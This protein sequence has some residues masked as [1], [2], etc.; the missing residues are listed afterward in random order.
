MCKARFTTLKTF[1]LNSEIKDDTKSKNNDETPVELIREDFLERLAEII[2]R[3]S[4]EE[5]AS[6]EHLDLLEKQNSKILIKLEREC[7][8]DDEKET[9]NLSS[10]ISNGTEKDNVGN[11]NKTSSSD[12]N[13]V[14]ESIFQFQLHLPDIDEEESDHAEE[15]AMLRHSFAVNNPIMQESAS[16]MMNYLH[17]SDRYLFNFVN[18]EGY[19]ET[20]GV[21]NLMLEQQRLLE[22]YNTGRGSYNRG[23]SNRSNVR[24]RISVNRGGGRGRAGGR[25]RRGRRA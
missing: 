16:N 19:V 9:T 3:E 21:E 12:N 11:S 6:L 13:N 24:I 17:D 14:D 2:D 5:L 1:G 18:D 22:Y 7:S 23:E 8:D 25:V 15:I 10:N 4:F 20:E